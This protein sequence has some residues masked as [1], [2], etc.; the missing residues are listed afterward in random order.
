[1]KSIAVSVGLL[2]SLI[3]HQ[4]F[5][6]NAYLMVF[7]DD[8][9]LRGVAVTLDDVPLGATD[10]RGSVSTRLD[11]GD[12][13]LLLSDDDISFPIE[14]SSSAGEDVEINV[15]FTRTEGDEPVV[16]VNRFAAG[17]TSASG[18][19]TGTVSNTAGTPIAGATVTVEDTDL[20]TVTDADGVYV[21]QVPR[22]E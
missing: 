4:V 14:F 3:S 12:H 11:A 20:S 5:A 19:I 16:T 17:D 8:A 18:Y 6:A 1:M 2:L 15:T 10:S 9:P 22:G 7:L 13:V 21:L